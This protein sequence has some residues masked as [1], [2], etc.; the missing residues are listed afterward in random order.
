MSENICGDS[1]DGGGIF[2]DFTV[3]FVQVHSAL[4]NGLL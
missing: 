2:C 3:N 4:A 1:G